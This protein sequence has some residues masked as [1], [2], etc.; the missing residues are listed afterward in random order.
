V[1]SLGPAS[2]NSALSATS[3]RVP[4]RGAPASRLR[5]RPRSDDVFD[6]TARRLPG[7]AQGTP[8]DDGLQ[9]AIMT[10]EVAVN[11]EALIDQL[12]TD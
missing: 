5:L 12:L 8:W 10:V 9:A 2:A 1:I 11:E 7:H 4:H 3:R 6:I